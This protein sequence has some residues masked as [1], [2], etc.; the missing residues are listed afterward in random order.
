[1]TSKKKRV[2]KKAPAKGAPKKKSVKKKPRT[3]LSPPAEPTNGASD[4]VPGV[5]ISSDVFGLVLKFLQSRPLGEVTQIWN[6]AQASP[7]T[8]NGSVLL[9]SQFHNG[10]MQYIESTQSVVQLYCALGGHRPTATSSPDVPAPPPEGATASR[11]L[12]DGL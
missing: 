7:R 9:S 8:E 6:A 11:G 2:A 5:L 1:M 12:E 10:L 3:G 4:V